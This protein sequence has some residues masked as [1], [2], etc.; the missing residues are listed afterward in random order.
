MESLHGALIGAERRDRGLDETEAGLNALIERR[1]ANAGD[2]EM[3]AEREEGWKESV[4]VYNAERREA[5]RHQWIA[6]YRRLAA[7]HAGLS[8]DLE[9]R[10]RELAGS[11]EG[12]S[13]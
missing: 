5:R 1:A 7:N 9:R 8:E 10:A 12:G 4:R 11:E 2:R 6:Y 3:A 13:V